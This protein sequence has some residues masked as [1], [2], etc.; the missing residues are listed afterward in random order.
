MLVCS[1]L[2][3]ASFIHVVKPCLS[4]INLL[5]PSANP[6]SPLVI[7]VKQI[8]LM[9]GQL[10]LIATKTVFIL[11]PFLDSKKVCHHHLM[12]YHSLRVHIYHFSK[13]ISVRRLHLDYQ[14]S[15]QS[16]Q[17]SHFQTWLSPRELSIS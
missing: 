12:N 10:D 8:E 2:I 9:G 6:S 1:K 11:N 17:Y 3:V 15:F 13:S 14:I 7:T 4:Y 5:G 16:S